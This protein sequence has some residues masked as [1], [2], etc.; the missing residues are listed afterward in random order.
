MDMLLLLLG[1]VVMA[2]IL[3][4]PPR[5]QVIY[6]PVEPVERQGDMGC[7]PLLIV[8]ILAL[9]VLGAIRI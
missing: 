6:I 9:L 2:M 5:T 4:R 3:F 7:L 8:G 1:I